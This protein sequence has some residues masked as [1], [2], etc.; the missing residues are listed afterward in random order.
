M[1]MPANMRFET[2]NGRYAVATSVDNRTFYVEKVLGK[3]LDLSG[4]LRKPNQINPEG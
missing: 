4:R 3:P 1:K 2:K